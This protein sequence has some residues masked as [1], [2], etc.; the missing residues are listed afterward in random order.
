LSADRSLQ[1][2]GAL[3]NSERR[4]EAINNRVS[5]HA[6]PLVSIIMPTHD[7]ASIISE[8]IATVREQDY[9]NWELLVCDD[10]STDN[11]EDVVAGFNDRRIRYLKLGRGGAAAARNAGLQE[12]RGSVIA[13]LDSDNFWHPGFLAAMVRVLEENPGRSAAYAS[14][15]DFHVDASGRCK[16][17]EARFPGFH[18]ERLLEKNYIDLN[19]FIHRR[20]LYDRF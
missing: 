11:T 1:V 6:R 12:A 5:E 19:T 7:R 8:A 20:E 14:Y 10:A 9:R 13:Y 18:H 2:E 16:L 15:I 3:R 4:L 17:R